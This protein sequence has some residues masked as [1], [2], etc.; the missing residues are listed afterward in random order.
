MKKIIIFLN[1]TVQIFCSFYACDNSDKSDC[2]EPVPE[3]FSCLSFVFYG[4]W[5]VPYPIEKSEQITFSKISY[6]LN[7]QRFT[8]E[9]IGYVDD[10]DGLLDT[11]FFYVLNGEANLTY[12]DFNPEDKNKYENI[13]IDK[14]ENTCYFITDNNVNFDKQEVNNKT[15]CFEAS[16]IPILMD[17]VDC[18]YAI[19]K[20]EQGN[21]IKTCLPI[22]GEKMPRKF[23]PYLA[24]K[25]GYDIFSSNKPFEL[26]IEKKNGEK[27]I[28]QFSN[29]NPDFGAFFNV[30]VKIK[31]CLD[32]EN[33]NLGIYVDNETIYLERV[34]NCY[35]FN[36]IGIRN[37][38]FSLKPFLY[39]NDIVI[40]QTINYKTFRLSEMEGEEG[41]FEDCIYKKEYSLSLECEI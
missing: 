39:K 7:I 41:M 34:D 30:T 22:P 32:L 27:L 24:Y 11:P 13:L 9:N 37:N 31:F 23:I 19:M 25:L 28:Y 38:E 21:E 10:I 14:F 3:G 17:I 16:Q 18:G 4:S 8:F 33:I 26:K 40:R 6:G 29:E 15:K 12:I 36:Q 35:W 1:L 5:C 20:D 2:K